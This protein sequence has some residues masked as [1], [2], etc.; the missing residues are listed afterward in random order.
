MRKHQQQQI[1]DILQ[2]LREAQKAD[3]YA[4]CQDGALACADFI[5]NIAGGDTETAGFLREYYDLLFKVHSGEAKK[6]TLKKQLHRIECSVRAKLKPDK[7]EVVFFPYKASMWDSMESIWLAAKAD[8]ACDA[9]VVPIP[10]YDKNTDGSFGQMHYEGGLYPD[11][12]PVSD[13]QSY[14]PEVRRPDAVFV[15]NPYDENNYV[16]SIHPDFYCKRLREFT[17]SL[18][19][20]PYYVSTE[21]KFEEISCVSPGTLYS[22]KTILQSEK[23]R[24]EYIRNIENFKKRTDAI[25]K[26]VK[27]NDK[28]LA[29]GSPKFDAAINK[30]RGDFKLPDEWEKLIGGKKVVLYNTSISTML[31]GDEQYLR[32]LRSVI[33]TFKKRYD[34]AVWWRPHPLS[35]STYGAMRPHLLSEYKRIIAEY[36]NAGFG[37]YDDSSDLHR[38]IAYA[39]MC[40]G[41]EYSSV[42]LL[43]QAAGK[44]LLLQNI[45]LTESGTLGSRENAE[46]SMSAFITISEKNTTYKY[47]VIETVQTTQGSFTLIDFIEFSDL[48]IKHGEAQ[49]GKYRATFANSDGTA[50]QK[51]YEHIKLDLKYSK[52]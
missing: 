15:H 24:Q 11:Y 42:N 1:L 9:Y 43:L 41:D 30:K 37:I 46:E 45:N 4:D 17:E 23:I 12:V 21:G 35:E 22:H 31:Q 2:T 8:P 48:I 20:V 44:P 13:W 33:E 47:I 14:N 19:Y 6:D 29:L 50:G 28:F 27:Q 18:I 10:Y 32:K 38:A 40:L 36:K 26:S 34:I 52:I 3:L 7:I 39:D 51:I 25:D 5:D 49:A 16:T